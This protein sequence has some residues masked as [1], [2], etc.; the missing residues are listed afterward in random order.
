MAEP[1]AMEATSEYLRKEDFDVL[2]ER[3]MTNI[4]SHIDQAVQKALEKN[5]A[6]L[7][8]RI[9][10]T[11]GEIRG[12]L[13]AK[14]DMHIQQEREQR[15]ADIE[16]VRKQIQSIGE[17]TRTKID[18]FNRMVGGATKTVEL[19]TTKM[20][21]WNNSL[22]A[23]QRLFEHNSKALE[24]QDSELE[25]LKGDVGTLEETQ[26]RITG[27]LKSINHAIYGGTG[28]GPKSLFALIED[29]TKEM[30]AGFSEQ[31]SKAMAALELARTTATRQDKYE[32]DLQARTQRWAKRRETARTAIKEAARTPYFWA[33]M[34]IIVVMMVAIF[35]PEALPTFIEFV[36]KLLGAQP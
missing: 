25:K 8:E 29:Q 14:L 4:T 12:E 11:K 27:K 18:E 13:N 2:M 26:I 24:R 21:G 19:L 1:I 23:N 20:D 10:A 35:R 32:Q 6:K 30:R 31:N 3:I 34:A 16:S 7:E 28:S 22:E 33:L 15:Q 17:E 36:S 5:D 9:S